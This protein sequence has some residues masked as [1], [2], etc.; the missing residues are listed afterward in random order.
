MN[1]PH[2]AALPA[3]PLWTAVHVSMLVATE[4]RSQKQTAGHIGLHDSILSGFD[5]N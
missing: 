1:S 4:M 2:S 3:A 5:R